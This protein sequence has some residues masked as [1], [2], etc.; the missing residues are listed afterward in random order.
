M[1]EDL[2]RRLVSHHGLARPQGLGHEGVRQILGRLR[3]IQ[4]DPLDPLGSQADLVALARVDELTRGEVYD[5]LLPGHAFEH[6]AKERCLLPRTAFPHYRRAARAAPW[7]RTTERMKRLTEDQLDAVEDEVRRRGPLSPS[8]LSDHGRVEP[9]DWNGWKGTGKAGTMALEVLAV[10]CR[11]V[12]SGRSGREKVYDLPERSLGELPEPEA[13]FHRWALAERVEACGMLSTAT[14][15]WWGQLHH[16]RQTVI[17]EALAAGEVERVE[18]PG[19]R[20]AWLAPAGFRDRPVEEPDDRMRILG[21]LDPLIWDR[22]LVK[23]LFGFDYVWEVYKPAKDR[24]WG[25]YV[26]PLLH[27]GR[28]VGRLDARFVDGRI[29]V[30]GRWVEEGEELDERAFEEALHRHEQALSGAAGPPPSAPR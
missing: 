1:L 7:W 16:V 23:L 4:L 3:C 12:V 21:P 18:L 5:A 2:R 10:R 26:V 8:Q 30:D 25:W 13:D 6:F 14:G 20:R 11:V 29:R 27:R 28:F 24:R 9:L 19:V 22:T 15:P 17:D